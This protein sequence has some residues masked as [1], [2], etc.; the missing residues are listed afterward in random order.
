MYRSMHLY[1]KKNPG[2]DAESEPEIVIKLRDKCYFAYFSGFVAEKIFPK[3]QLV[4]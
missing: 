1:P 3:N 4:L 2:I